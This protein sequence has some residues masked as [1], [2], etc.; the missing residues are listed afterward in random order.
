MYKKKKN[1]IN[2]KDHKCFQYDVPITL[3]YEKK[4]KHYERMSKIKPFINNHE[5]EEIKCSKHNDDWKTFDKNNV[6]IVLKVS[7]AKKEQI[8]PA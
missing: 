8:Y 4:E 5:Q 7:Y 1:A 6:A 2:I 3:H